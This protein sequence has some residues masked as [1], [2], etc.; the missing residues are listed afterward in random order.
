MNPQQPPIPRT[1]G[2][3][4]PGHSQTYASH[5]G[6]YAGAQG[7]QQAYGSTSQFAPISAGQNLNYAGGQPG[8]NPGQ[9]APLAGPQATTANAPASGAAAAMTSTDQVV[10]HHLQKRGYQQPEEFIRSVPTSL[11]TMT[12]EKSVEQGLHARNITKTSNKA[13]NT[14]DMYEESY[15]RLRRFIESSLDKYRNELATVLWP[16]FV[17]VFLDMVTK[18]FVH[19]GECSVVN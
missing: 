7:Q 14:P 13:E 18:G 16:V 15:A 2:L 19:E 11:A 8:N 5:Q 6:G 3:S 4:L 10:Y 1:S 9:P 17:Y 12:L